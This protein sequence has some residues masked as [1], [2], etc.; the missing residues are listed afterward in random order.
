MIDPTSPQIS[1]PSALFDSSWQ[2]S[3][4]EGLSASGQEDLGKALAWALPRYARKGEVAGGEPSSDHA[5][6]VVAILAGLQ[7]DSH[8]RMAALLAVAVGD[9]DVSANPNKDPVTLQ[10][11]PEVGRLVHGYRALIRLG[12]MTRDASDSA[13]GS[14]AQSEMLRKML[15][16]MAAD[17]R[18]VLMRLASRLQT[19]RWHAQHK[20]ALPE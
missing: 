19:L 9:G 13:A 3:A 16:A 10:F 2:K 20:L 11:G 14:G 18:I 1:V 6:G 12:Q 15:L 8:T 5:A 7:V 17:L 4:N